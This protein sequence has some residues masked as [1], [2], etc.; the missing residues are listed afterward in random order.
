M[1]VDH[2]KSDSEDDIADTLPAQLARKHAILMTESLKRKSL[3]S[4]QD[5]EPK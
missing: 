5:L 1:I 2:D 4:Y 3:S